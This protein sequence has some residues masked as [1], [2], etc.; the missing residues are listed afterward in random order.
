MRKVLEMRRLFEC[1]VFRCSFWEMEVLTGF[2]FG[3]AIFGVLGYTVDPAR[4][5]ETD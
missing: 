2:K 4:N 3:E 5:R 1:P